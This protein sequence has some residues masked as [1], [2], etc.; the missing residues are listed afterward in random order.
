MILRVVLLTDFLADTLWM[1]FMVMSFMV[2]QILVAGL[3]RLVADMA[4]SLVELVVCK[5]LF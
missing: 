2:Y 5:L 4:V 3:G 1:I